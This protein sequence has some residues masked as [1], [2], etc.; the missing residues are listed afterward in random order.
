MFRSVIISLHLFAKVSTLRL[1]FL[2]PLYFGI[3]HIHHFYEFTLTHPYT[4]LVPSLLLSLFQ[5]AYTSIFGFYAAFLFLR[6]GSL[7]AVILAHSFCNWMGLPRFWGRL[8]PPTAI[9]PPDV[10]RKEDSE[11]LLHVG[12]ESLEVA[13]GRLNIG[14]TIVYYLLLIA[15]AVLFY[16]NLWPLTESSH[17]LVSFHGKS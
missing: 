3:A 6:T 1:I 10:N 11:N 5:F 7:P 14:W 17:A 16:R 4:P 15:G 12:N 9:G 13:G 2:T 8:D